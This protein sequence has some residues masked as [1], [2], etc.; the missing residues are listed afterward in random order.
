[1][2][3]DLETWLR[4]MCSRNR[5]EA[6]VARIFKWERKRWGQ[7]EIK[8]SLML[9][10]GKTEVGDVIYRK[11]WDHHGCSVEHAILGD[12]RE[13]GKQV[14]D[15]ALIYIRLTEAFNV[16]NVDEW[17]GWGL[18]G[19]SG[20]QYLLK[21]WRKDMLK[22]EKLENSGIMIFTWLKCWEI[23]SGLG[24]SGVWGA[25]Q[26]LEWILGK[27]QGQRVVWRQGCQREG[28][29]EEPGESHMEADG[30]SGAHRWQVDMGWGTFSG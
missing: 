4:M 24:L 8:P 9:Y 29:I 20:L 17:L 11:H 22:R 19:Q 23:K 27:E 14:G 28:L 21:G 3:K 6:C 15:N 26:N 12:K 7:Q 18:C 2:C 25:G 1:M 16:G 5:K 30:R 10:H 13:G